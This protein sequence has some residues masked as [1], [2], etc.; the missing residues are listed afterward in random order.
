MIS[1][2]AAMQPIANTDGTVVLDSKPESLTTVVYDAI[3]D[4]IINRA[5]APGSRVTEAGLAAQLGVSK[6]PVREALLKLRQV[7]LIE[8]AG[9]RGGRI[10]L[11]SRTSIRHAYETRE[12]LESYAARLAAERAGD[13]DLEQ[14]SVTARTCLA[15]AQDGDLSGFRAW[16]GQFHQAVAAATANPQLIEL[17]ENA[18]ALV[19]TLRR[20]DVPHAEASVACAK[21]HVEIARAIEAGD[22]E[23]AARTMQAHVRQV[24]GYVLASVAEDPDDRAA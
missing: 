7:G 2:T 21:A 22:A 3:R 13:S 11:P 5:L 1:N 12:A 4:A 17:I 8:P 18:L 19:V 23:T 15:C 24:E 6:T 10:A 20:R 14:I 9:R 16:D